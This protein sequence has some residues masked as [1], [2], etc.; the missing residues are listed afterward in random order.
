MR[1]SV[2][3]LQEGWYDNGDKYED[4]Y[5]LFKWPVDCSKLWKISLKI[6]TT[7][8]VLLCDGVSGVMGDFDVDEDYVDEEVSIPIDTL[9]CHM[10]S[11][12]DDIA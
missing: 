11:G 10:T 4:T 1:E 9:V 8:F 5:P 6:V 7:K 12:D 3:S 2:E